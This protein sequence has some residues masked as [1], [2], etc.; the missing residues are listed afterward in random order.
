MV[1]GE[2]KEL[3]NEVLKYLKRFTQAQTVDLDMLLGQIDILE[4]NGLR[5]VRKRFSSEVGILK[6]LPP[7]IF[8]KASYPF[9]INPSERFRREL[10]FFN[11]G[12]GRFYS[13]PRL[14]GVDEG[15]LIIV[16]EYVDGR[17][18][19]Y[20]R[21]SCELLSKALAEIHSRGYVLGDVKPSN[22][23]INDRGIWVIDAEQAVVTSNEVLFGWDLIL[24]MFFAS[25]K[26]VVDV[27]NFKD[28]IK[29][30]IRG[31][32]GS[33][34]KVLWVKSMF[35]IKNLGIALLIPPHTLKV[36]MEELSEFTT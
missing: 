29:S 32:L 7:S 6:W 28:F 35:S 5:V 25:Y 21:E 13:V 23:V 24:T 3:L 11:L 1:S 31:Y 12:S 26:Y 4:V 2:F 8:Y 14:Y 34:G 10:S 19:S 20:D 22:F 16:R 30:F 17:K 15:N 36:L 18:L 33:G 27:E 9:T